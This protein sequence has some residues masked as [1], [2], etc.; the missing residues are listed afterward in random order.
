MATAPPV[1]TKPFRLISKGLEAKFGFF[2]RGFDVIAILKKQRQA[3]KTCECVLEA[4]RADAVPAV[5][6]KITM[7]FQVSGDSLDAGKVER[8]VALSA[9]KYCSAS[10]M[11]EDAGVELTHRVTLTS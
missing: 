11:L 2:S 9:E 1:P 5:F 7:D 4:E 3:I 6:T 8:A 10:K